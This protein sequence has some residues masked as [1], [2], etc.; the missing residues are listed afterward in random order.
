MSEYAS[1]SFTLSP[2]ETCKNDMVQMQSINLVCPVCDAGY[3]NKNEFYDH[4][5]IHAGDVLLKHVECL[6]NANNELDTVPR[7][8]IPKKIDETILRPFK[9]QQCSLTFDRASQYDYHYRSIH[10]GEKSQLCEICGKGFFRKADLRTHLNIHLGTNVCICEICGRKFN[11]ISNLIRHCRMHAGIKLYPCSI[12][13]KRFTQISSITRHKRIHERAKDDVKLHTQTNSNNCNL[14]KKDHAIYKNKFVEGNAPTQQKIVKRQHYC[15]ICGESFNFIFLLREHEKSH[16]QIL[17]CKDHEK[18]TELKE[19]TQHVNNFDFLENETDMKKALP[20]DAIIYITSEQ[21]KKIN[22][23]NIE[24]NRNHVSQEDLCETKILGDEELNVS[25]KMA[26]NSEQTQLVHDNPLLLCKSNDS[27]ESENVS[28]VCPLDENILKDKLCVQTC[29]T[30]LEKSETIS[31]YNTLMNTPLNVADLFQKIDLSESNSNEDLNSDPSIH[32]NEETLV[33][34]EKIS[35]DLSDINNIV[36]HDE[37]MLRL[38]QTETGE[39]FYEFLI[40]NLVEKLPNS[41]IIESTKNS[42]SKDDSTNMNEENHEGQSIRDDIHN[43][44]NYS[45]Y[46]LQGEEKNFTNQILLDTQSDFDKY[47]E[48]NFEVF[49]RLN[50]DDS[51]ERFLE[52]VESGLENQSSK[53]S[54][55]SKESDEFLQF[56]NFTEIDTVEPNEKDSIINDNN[57]NN[58]IIEI[59][60]KQKQNEDVTNSNEKLEDEQD[61]K[62]SKTFLIKFQCTVCEKSFSTS[63]NYKQHIGTHFADQQKFHCKDCKLSFAWKSTLNKHIANNHRPDGPQKFACDICNKIYNT[64]SQVNEHV[65]RDHLKQ[66]NH[67]CSQCGKSFFKKYDL[68][69]HNRIHTDE[70]P[71]VC[72]ACGK[73]FH[74]RSHIIRHERIHF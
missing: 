62:K 47:V 4:L 19:Q 22:L 68:K 18:A 61:S 40:N 43:D 38:V 50:Y 10:L 46:E 54:D 2:E 58:Q 70:R 12:C 16:L 66:R 26:F 25:E 8:S 28:Y 72:R 73:R 27:I 67:V 53:I 41:Q 56:Q 63:Y 31:S 60:E 9:C 44:L 65:K 3:I 51:P 42:E 21:L 74:H 13:G 5:S 7:E 34:N 15:K 11:H 55:F 6:K 71:Y 17:E 1:M 39:Q 48:T 37:P 64:S 49:E 24:D 20:L 69:I 30:D 29:E 35:D 52:F 33:Q 57:S 36:N 45:Q 14:Q 23:E 59:D 32:K